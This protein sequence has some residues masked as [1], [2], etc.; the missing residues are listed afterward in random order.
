MEITKEQIAVIRTYLLSFDEE[1]RK[2]ILHANNS[3]FANYL[4]AIKNGFINDNDIQNIGKEIEN[5]VSPEI[6][7]S[8]KNE[9]FLALAEIESDNCSNADLEKIK[10]QQNHSFQKLLSEFSDE[11]SFQ[12]DLK[13][14]FLLHQR[15]E[16]RKIFTR[17]DDEDEFDI[18]DEQMRDAMTLHMRENLKRQFEEIDKEEDLINIKEI[19]PAASVASKAQ[20]F[21]RFAKAACL[22]GILTGSVYFVAINLKSNKNSTPAVTEFVNANKTIDT[23]LKKPEAG[24]RQ[25]IQSSPTHVKKNSENP[26]IADRREMKI[27]VLKEQTGLGFAGTVVNTDSVIIRQNGLLRT[28][29]DT[30]TYDSVKKIIE[31]NLSK[32]TNRVKLI[33]LQ[34]TEKTSLFLKI[35]NVFFLIHESNTLNPLMPVTNKNTIDSLERILFS[36]E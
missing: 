25:N 23:S 4:S 10:G 8:L 21:L 29:F 35:E 27:Q 13:Q 22:V 26:L 6:L 19:V 18:S 7:Q 2:G 36:N 28:D 16:F 15:E 5:G 24:E 32:T 17:I 20:I 12:N 33:S 1:A 3:E 14:A 30:Y 11:L 9:Y 31:L 34:K